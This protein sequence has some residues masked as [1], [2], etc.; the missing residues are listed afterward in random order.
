MTEHDNTNRGAAFTP[1]PEQKFILSGRINYHGTDRNVAL[2]TGETKD[3]K[4][5]IEVYQKIGIMFENDR[6]DVPAKPDYTGMID[7]TNL[8]L[9]AWR[10]DKDGKPYL[11]Y[12]VSEK[13]EAPQETVPQSPQQDTGQDVNED[14]PF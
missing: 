4:K 13:Q 6:K 10:G 3:G 12:Q 7:N 5:K 8:R 1:Y 11:S 14:V 2:I 9:A